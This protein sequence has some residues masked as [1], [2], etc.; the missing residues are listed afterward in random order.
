MADKNFALFR[1]KRPG[2]CWLC[3]KSTDYLEGHHLRYKPPI[4][5]NLCH[6]CHHKIHFFPQ[7]I[8]LAQRRR[9]VINAMSPT[10]KQVLIA[11][12]YQTLTN[13]V[14]A[15]ADKMHGKGRKDMK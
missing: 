9:I 4:V 10:E 5:R 7:R 3:G 6:D 14:E 1:K 13:E 12:G 8:S 15:R 11:K 2:A